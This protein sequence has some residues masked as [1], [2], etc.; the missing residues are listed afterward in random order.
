MLPKDGAGF[1]PSS[2]QSSLSASFAYAPIEPPL[3]RSWTMFNPITEI[4][5]SFG[6]WITSPLCV[7]R[8]IRQLNGC[9]KPTGS[10]K[11][12]MPKDTRWMK[13]I[14]GGSDK[15]A[16]DIYFLIYVI[17]Y[18]MKVEIIKQLKCSRCNHGWNPRKMEVR[19]CPR[20]HSPYWDKERRGK[21]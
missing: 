7:P 8:V 21:K 15:L 18:N 6:I 2:W 3:L 4:L 16:V 11:D 19:V 1:A 14:Y 13:V 17:I 10:V 5:F 12:A 20:C 9:K